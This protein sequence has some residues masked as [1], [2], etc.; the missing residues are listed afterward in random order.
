MGRSFGIMT[1]FLSVISHFVSFGYYKMG[2]HQLHIPGFGINYSGSQVQVPTTVVHQKK[3][4]KIK[5][6]ICIFK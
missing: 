4:K 2:D 3:I 1:L 5:N 6:Y